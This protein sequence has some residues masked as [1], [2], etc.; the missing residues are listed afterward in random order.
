MIF[1]FTCTCMYTHDHCMRDEPPYPT[2][3]NKSCT[4]IGLYIDLSEAI[5]IRTPDKE[6]T[7]QVVL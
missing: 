3:V 4:Y 1:V 2:G 5:D 7:S 6:R